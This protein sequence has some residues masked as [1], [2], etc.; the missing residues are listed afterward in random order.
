MKQRRQQ[1]P[2]AKAIRSN[3][4][5]IAKIIDAFKDLD[6]ISKI[7]V[8]THI[9]QKFD[10]DMRA[11]LLIESNK[12]TY[13]AENTQNGKWATVPVATIAAPV[14]IPMNGTAVN[15]EAQ[16]IQVNC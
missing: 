11:K 13:G 5:T 16:R 4:N 2:E 15:P 14:Q 9:N 8:R 6:E 7:V 3:A 1:S 12:H 10:S